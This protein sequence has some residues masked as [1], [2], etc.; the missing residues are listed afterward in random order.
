QPPFFDDMRPVPD[1]P[2]DIRGARVLAMFGDMFTTDHISPIG[3]ISKGTPAA[4]Y[5][6]SL[7]IAP[8]DFVNY[9]ARR[10]NHDVMI[11][12]TFA[13]VRVR[14]EMTPEVEGSST[15]HYPDRERMPI[16]A[17]AERYRQEGV[18]LVVIAGAEYGAGSSRDWATRS[19]TWLASP[20]PW[21]RAA[22]WSARLPAPTARVTRSSCSRASIPGATSS[23]FATAVCCTTCCGTA[24]R[25][26]GLH[27]SKEKAARA[28]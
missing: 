8:V 2:G 6:L 13:N 20:A 17:A 11:R 4:E 7:G 19:S 22:S 28:A 23:I 24:F 15:V 10:L 21:R 5:L 25:T 1:E 9:A 16:H 18:P 26:R 14:N 27:E 12:G 3:V